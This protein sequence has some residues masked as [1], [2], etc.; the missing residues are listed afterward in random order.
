MVL[1]LK[2]QYIYSHLYFTGL[3]KDFDQWDY[4]VEGMDENLI[5]GPSV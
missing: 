2:A 4:L 3:H 5:P 1:C